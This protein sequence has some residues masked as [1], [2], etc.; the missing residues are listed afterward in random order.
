[1][2][3]TKPKPK[4]DLV[5][6]PNLARGYESEKVIICNLYMEYLSRASIVGVEVNYDEEALPKYGFDWIQNNPNH[7]CGEM[8]NLPRTKT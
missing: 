7:K 3:M 1:M 5:C 6:H 8:P 2:H 4:Q